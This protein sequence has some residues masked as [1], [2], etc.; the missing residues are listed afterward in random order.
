MAAKIRI[1]GVTSDSEIPT[2]S[3]GRSYLF[4]NK[5]DFLYKA[6]LDDGSIVVLSVNEEYVE[7]IVGGMLI[8]TSTI[9]FSY[10]DISGE[11]TAVVKPSSIDTS[12][13]DTIAPTK[14][15]DSQNGRY[16]AT[17]NTTNNTFTTAFSLDCSTDGAVFLTVN[18]T[19]FRTGGSG[20]TAG[21]SGAFKRSIRVK[22][23]G[24]VV[25]LHDSQSDYT[26]R[27]AAS[28]QVDFVV[29]GT[30]VNVRVRGAT[31]NNIRWYLD[32]ATNINN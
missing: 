28:M 17:V 21:D 12:H 2:P 19:C 20:G 3:S 7:D 30:D 1:Q 4:Y 5:T 9:D 10:N 25:T 23:I 18:A 6:R 24:G 15:V 26:S 13:V 32:I 11:V 27:D 14:I 16:E 29:S 31:N 22:T 8:D